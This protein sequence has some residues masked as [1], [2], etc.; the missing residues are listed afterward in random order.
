MEL[1]NYKQF[2]AP[3]YWFSALGVVLI[4]LGLTGGANVLGVDM[5]IV[6]PIKSYIALGLG[7]VFLGCG[8][9][10]HRLALRESNTTDANK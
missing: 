6:D 3:R 1:N 7:V 5:T 2:I 9:R 8:L 4:L 10:L